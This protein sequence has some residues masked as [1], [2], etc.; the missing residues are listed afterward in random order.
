MKATVQVVGFLLLAG[1]AG[2]V[3]W[4]RHEQRQRDRQEIERLHG[5]LEQSKRA[6]EDP[7]FQQRLKER[8][9]EAAR[10][11]EEA[12]KLEAEA[13]RLKAEEKAGRSGEPERGK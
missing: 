3:I 5:L 4:H 9:A 2:F 13:R 7:A 12:R 10:L 8:E 6:A 11:M 1:L